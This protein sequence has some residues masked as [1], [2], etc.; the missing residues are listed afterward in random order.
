MNFESLETQK[1]MPWEII[2]IRTKTIFKSLMIIYI[3]N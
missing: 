1:I 2:A 3:I